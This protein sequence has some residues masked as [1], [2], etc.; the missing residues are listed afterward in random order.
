MSPTTTHPSAGEVKA[1]DY[2]SR[3]TLATCVC[4][5]VCFAAYMPEK[6]E[7]RRGEKASCRQRDMS[8]QQQ[9]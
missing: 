4:V 6:K 5:C 1:T 3:C 2:K 9:H 7:A 8:Q